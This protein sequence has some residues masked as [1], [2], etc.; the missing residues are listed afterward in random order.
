MRFS[1]I[2]R[3]AVLQGL[4]GAILEVEQGCREA[5]EVENGSLRLL[6]LKLFSFSPD[7]LLLDDVTEGLESSSCLWLESFLLEQE[8]KILLLASH[9]R[10]FMD[11]LCNVVIAIHKSRCQVLPG[12]YSKAY[13]KGGDDLHFHSFSLHQPKSV[14]L[15]A[16]QAACAFGALVAKDWKQG[17]V[18]DV[19]TGTGLLALILAQEVHRRGVSWSGNR[20]FK[21]RFERE[22]LPKSSKAER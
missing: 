19:G 17:R 4:K 7:V 18:V 22:R 9:D 8:L 1:G 5:V 20:C 12:S 21:G 13:L 14:G 16:T 10:C 11:R 2:K 6:L 3:L 15:R